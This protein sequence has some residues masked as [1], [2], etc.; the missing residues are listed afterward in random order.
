M[1]FI[2]SSCLI[3]MARPSSTM[4]NRRG[5]SRHPCLVPNPSWNACSFCT[6]SMMLAVVCCIWPYYVDVCS[7]LFH[8]AESF[9]H[10]W[11]VDFIK[12]FFCIYWY[13]HVVF[14]FHFVYVVNHI[15]W[16]ANVVSTLHSQNET[17]LTMVYDHFVCLFFPKT[18]LLLFSYSCL[19]FFPLLSHTLPTPTLH[20]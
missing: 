2:S 9:C 6:L 4:L 8:F 11:V 12:C 3:S 16:F 19:H 14:I 7:L 10:K 17:H 15:Y 1:P 13:D 5:E 18:F 20:I